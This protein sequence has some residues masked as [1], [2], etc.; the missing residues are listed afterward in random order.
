MRASQAGI[1]LVTA[2][3]RFKDVAGVRTLFFDKTGTLT[4]GD[5]RVR[6]VSLE[7][8]PSLQSVLIWRAIWELEKDVQHPV[9]HAI[10]RSSTIQQVWPGGEIG[11]R[12]GL[13][14]R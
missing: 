12:C 14:T 11:R 7:P 6:Y 1:R 9:A 4:R 8:Y 5:L 2:Y 3:S 10:I 13:K